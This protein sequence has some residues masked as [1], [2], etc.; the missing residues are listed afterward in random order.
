MMTTIAL[1]TLLLLGSCVS[2]LDPVMMPSIN[3]S[4]ID[5]TEGLDVTATKQVIEGVY[6]VV[7]EESTTSRFDSIIS[8]NLA[9]NGEVNMYSTAGVTYF[10]LYGGTRNDSGVFVGRWRGVQGPSAGSI[11]MIVRP[12]EGGI[13]LAKG[14]AASKD[15]TLRC[16]TRA[17]NGNGSQTLVLR[18]VAKL[19]EDLRGF[20]IIAH[21]GGGR[22][23]ERLGVSENS[24]AMM[25]LA[26]QLGATGIEIDVMGTKDGTPIIFHD[27]SFTSRTIKGSYIIGPVNNYTLQQ[28]GH[29]VRLINGERI[30]TLKEALDSVIDRTELQ[31]VWLDVKDAS[32]VDSIL[33]IQKAANE[34]SK[35]KG[36]DLTIYFGVPT[37]DI[38]KAFDA[39]P[40]RTGVDVLCELDAQTAINMDAAVWAPRFTEG[41]QQ[42]LAESMID[43]GMRVFVWTLDD[44]EFIEQF[45]SPRYKNKLLYSGILTN[46]PTLLASQ[47]YRKVKR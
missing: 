44:A 42:G 18:R 43:A 46:Y 16:Q 22:N 47:F 45:L 37:T 29:Y 20:Q 23:S 33:I 34:R 9:S 38:K 30:P 27:P 7:L 36:R 39:S 12:D 25:L 3:M 15:L 11:T 19:D 31:M 24:I 13:E 14:V 17:G 35:T 40:E 10:T 6:K 4:T 21:R 8:V 5:G 32:I 26:P 41:V 1:L 2:E 28:I